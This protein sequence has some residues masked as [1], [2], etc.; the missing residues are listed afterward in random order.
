MRVH[1][2]K[3]HAMPVTEITR[4][5]RETSKW[6][7]AFYA[8]LAEK[9][10]RSG[11]LRTVQSYSRMLATFFAQVGKSPDRV[12]ATDVLTTCSTMETDLR[13]IR[14]TVP[15]AGVSPHS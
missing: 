8:F 12:V 6:D 14:A 3:E 13:D 4:L 5:D 2:S 9:E 15:V 1:L 7:D 11:S 10:R